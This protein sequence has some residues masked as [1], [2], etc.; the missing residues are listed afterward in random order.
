M[1]H[2]LTCVWPMIIQKLFSLSLNFSAC[3][4][5]YV[6][7]FHQLCRKHIPNCHST[8]KNINKYE[9]GFQAFA[10][11]WSNIIFFW[12]VPR[13]V[14]TAFIPYNQS[15]FGRIS[16]LL[17]KHNI[18]SIAMPPKKIYNYLPPVK[19]PLGLRIPGIY[20]IPCECGKVYVGQSGRAISL[21]IT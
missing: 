20:S 1:C 16:R 14:S 3:Q 2:L 11:L 6:Y 18:K 19:D 5:V 17:A 7:H 10:V 13:R 9:T 21:R 12:V 8:K 4:R 15:T